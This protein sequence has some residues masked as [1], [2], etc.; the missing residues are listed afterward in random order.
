MW[1]FEN[2]YL[3]FAVF[4]EKIQKQKEAGKSSSRNI[5]KVIDNQEKRIGG[6]APSFWKQKTSRNAHRFLKMQENTT[7]ATNFEKSKKIKTASATRFEK[8]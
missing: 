1:K 7:S 3:H 2:N 5:N 8:K 6:F 4:F